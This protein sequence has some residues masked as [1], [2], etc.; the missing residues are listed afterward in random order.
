MDT[1]SANSNVH[2]TVGAVSVQSIP[3]HSKKKDKRHEPKNGFEC[4]LILSSPC[5]TRHNLM[6]S[7][8]V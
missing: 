4:D 7:D 1:L 5:V 3:E 8:T 6:A 2:R